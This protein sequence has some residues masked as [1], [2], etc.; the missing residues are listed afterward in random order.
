MPR[1]LRPFV[2]FV[3]LAIF[4]PAGPA[5]AGERAIYAPEGVALAGHDPV[6]YFTDGHAVRGKQNYTLKWRGVLWRFTSAE[7]LSAF[8]AN[9]GAYA[10]EFGGYCPQALEQGKLLGGSPQVWVIQD[11]RLYLLSEAGAV[12]RARRNLTEMIAQARAN[13]RALRE[14]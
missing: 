9:P 7:H 10:P 13:W 3:M 5:A 4:A 12:T 11:G 8:E 2:L 1:L 6:A 14:Q